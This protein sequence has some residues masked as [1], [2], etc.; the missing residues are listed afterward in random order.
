ME[1]MAN[2][3]AGAAPTAGVPAGEAVA[4][5]SVS[6]EGKEEPGLLGDDEWGK[7]AKRKVKHKVDGKE[8]EISLEEALRGYSHSQAANKKFE[9]AATARKQVDADK[10]A[11]EEQL[12]QLKDPKAVRKLLSQ[13]LGDE[14][15][16][17][18]AHEE[19]MEALRREAMTPEELQA[20]EDRREL[21]EFKKE[22]VKRQ[23]EDN[24]QRRQAEVEK[25]AEDFSTDLTDTLT[26][27]GVKPQPYEMESMLDLMVDA[28][29]RGV[30]LDPRD[31]WAHVQKQ[32]SARFN[33][34]L[35]QLDVASLPKEFLD[36]VRQHIV[37]DVPMRGK[38]RVAEA[39]PAP[40]K[41]ERVDAGDFFAR[42][43]K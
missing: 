14:G 39:A 11:M 8:V 41:D 23:E 22:K 31:A 40:K 43:R 29:E 34:Y 16:K 28:L 35:N 24:K 9:E 20:E 25:F 32:E 38:P 30:D 18:L 10:R 15:F 13:H 3:A 5:E 7:V 42:M 33:R 36:K 19:V 2:P 17:Q 1:G 4:G 21:E 37:A 6:S 26:K 27:L 12:K